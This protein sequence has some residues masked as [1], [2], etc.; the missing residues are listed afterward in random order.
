MLADRLLAQAWRRSTSS[1]LQP[2]GFIEDA[3]AAVL[4]T[5]DAWTRLVGHF[6]WDVP[7]GSFRVTAQ[8]VVEQGRSDLRLT[9]LDGKQVVLE[10]KAGD[11]PARSQV[12]QYLDP[13]VLVIGLASTSRRYSHPQLVGTSTWTDVVNM[14]WPSPPLAWRQFV[15]LC[16]AIGVAMP[17]VDV[18]ALTGLLS[19]Y[20]AQGTMIR[21]AEEA[22]D[23]LA[24][25]LTGGGVEFVVRNKVKRA[26]RF[27]ERGHR[28]DVAWLW[29]LPWR[30]H[31]YAG[32]H[33]GLSFGIP[34]A[35]VLISGLPD[36]R[37][38]WQCNPGSDLSRAIATDSLL[39]ECA[40]AWAA[41]DSDDTVRAWDPGS[42]IQLEARTS[43]SL[44]LGRKCSQPP[45]IRRRARSPVTHLAVA[46]G[47]GPRRA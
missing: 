22:T 31:P 39:A 42:W 41:N 32:V 18:A 28:R 8:D 14:P 47:S 44:L 46:Q 21:W 24:A 9:F 19:S 13:N 25:L 20:D 3:L 34:S 38:C 40:R 1:N 16:Q 43:S 15:N 11:A 33:V 36:L 26:R 23:H 37:V 29:P 17:A 7:K 6:R 30:A 10:L 27:T 2:E 35:P 5:T 45:R 12:C 4:E